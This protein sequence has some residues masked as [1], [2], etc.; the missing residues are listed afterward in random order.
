MVLA[1]TG[2]A[3]FASLGLHLQEANDDINSGNWASLAFALPAA[4]G[5]WGAH[6]EQR[7][8]VLLGNG[9]LLMSAIELATLAR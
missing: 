7:P 3:T 2:D 4:V 6:P 8:L 1:D 9:A 5:A